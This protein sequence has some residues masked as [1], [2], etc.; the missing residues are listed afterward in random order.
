[1]YHRVAS[2]SDGGDPLQLCVDPGRFQ[3]QVALIRSLG[4]IVPLDAIAGDR[5]SKGVRFAITFDDG[6]AD[7]ALSAAPVLQSFDAP[8]TVFVV[9]GAV[10]SGS[11]FW[12][13]RLA[14]LLFRDGAPPRV[15]L[16]AAG[17]TVVVDAR[18]PAGRERAYWAAWSR[19]RLL[20]SA[21]IEE[22]LE[23]LTETLGGS[24]PPVARPL[25][26]AEL[27]TLAEST[28]EIGAHT[29]SHPSLSAIPEEEQRREILG[30]RARLE[31]L[32]DRPVT[33]FAY[34]YGDYDDR[35][36]RV[37]REGRFRAACSV[38]EGRVSPFSLRWRLPRFAARDW[39]A[40]ELEQRLRGWLRA[41]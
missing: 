5:R 22:S 28:V 13:D 19:L 21:Q 32:L 12:W 15:E 1:M 36:V 39:G 2:A 4:E 20:P 37:V 41:W 25:S 18:S 30:G 6:Y 29:L 27:Q 26:E 7:N 17:R 35:A 31:E 16:T 10:G 14:G 23:R 40:D 24:A 9:A 3:E 8:A 34:P 11:T 38:N 33:M